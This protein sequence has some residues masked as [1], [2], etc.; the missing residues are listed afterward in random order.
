MLSIYSNGES[1]VSG[2]VTSVVA[3]FKRENTNARVTVR[4]EV[5][6]ISLYSRVRTLAPVCE[7]SSLGER[8]AKRQCCNMN[9]SHLMP[10]SKPTFREPLVSPPDQPAGGGGLAGATSW[11][12]AGQEEI[13]FVRIKH[14][15]GQ[16]MAMCCGGLAHQGA[17]VQGTEQANGAA[18]R[19]RGHK[20][21]AYSLPVA[22]RGRKDGGR[23]TTKHCCSAD[24]AV[25]RWCMIASA[26]RFQ[27]CLGVTH[28]HT[29]NRWN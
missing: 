8:M 16:L 29:H 1:V 13:V 20:R 9:L 22:S 26:L 7:G 4:S 3:V 18:R 6:R 12:A 10:S 23:Q 21:T 11:Q 24:I 17:P 28:T 15:G 2:L 5:S 19:R 27:K 25:L 14:Y